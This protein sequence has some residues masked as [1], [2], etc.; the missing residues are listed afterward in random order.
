MNK[1]VNPVLAVVII[2]LFGSLLWLKFHFYGKAL[3]VPKVAFL[4]E[5]PDNTIFIR[6]GSQLYQ[7]QKNEKLKRIIDLQ[8]LGIS[9]EAG[10]F[11]FFSNGDLLI[12]SDEYHGNL[13]ENLA[14]Y[15][16]LENTTTAPAK[17]G[18]GLLRCK[19]FQPLARQHCQVF[20]NSIPELQGPHYIHIDRHTDN[21]YLA[22]TTRHEVRKLS[23]DGNLLAEITTGLKFPNQV[24]LERDNSDN[25]KGE[26]LWVVDTNH[27]EMKAFK[28]DTKNFGELIEK[29][30]T[31][32]DGEWIWP[33][34]FSKLANGWAIQIADNAMQNAK[35]V[36]YDNQWQ[37]GS[38]LNLPSMADPVSSIFS[39]N[40]L[41]IA[42]TNNYTLYQFDQYGTRLS[43]FAE[44]ESASGIHAALQ[45]NKAIDK[46]YRQWSNWVLYLGLGL[47]ALFFIYALKQSQ[48]EQA[49]QEEEAFQNSQEIEK[50]KIIQLAKLPMEGEWIKA[51]SH[52]RKLKWIIL[53]ADFLIVALLA[54]LFI[55]MSNKTPLELILIA[56]VF[57]AIIT[58]SMIP[59]S[60]ISQ[61][62]IGFFKNNVTIKTD[63]GKL[64]SAPYNKIKWG[65]RFFS[66]GD[67]FIPIGNPSQSIFPY[68][69]L[70][71]MLMPYVLPE[72]K[73][74]EIDAFKLQWKSPD[75]VLKYALLSVGLGLL[76]IIILKRHQLMGL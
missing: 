29:H 47:F 32:L 49:E 52:F 33:S 37:Q 17:A 31:T 76:L 18:K 19:L 45:A 8:K 73:L 36:L 60:K 25:S 72:N 40:T 59:I 20:N 39:N 71:N 42:D 34:A 55:T 38:L 1:N 7:Y 69:K 23:P 68:E 62:Q 51:K 9:G 53:G 75:G 70:Q 64:I 50:D 56:L 24:F 74:G 41:I 16:R 30:R 13:K 2:A 10:D 4:K 3:E 54:Y 22:D 14:A 11:D 61:Y 27:H 58:I 65:N 46:Q 28:A 6:L 48:K 66:I 12:N 57:P 5:A 35:I 26:K 63:K 21:V 44:N 67:W 43:N 15:A